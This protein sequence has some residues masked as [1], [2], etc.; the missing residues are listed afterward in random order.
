MRVSSPSQIGLVQIGDRFG[1]QYYLPYAISLLQAYAKTHL[2]DPA[3]VKFGTPLYYRA[4]P[5]EALRILTGSQILFFSAYLWNY[6]LSIKIAK[7]YKVRHPETIIV[8]GGPQVP[9]NPQRL[10][11]FMTEHPYIDI[12]CYGE[13][14]EPFLQILEQ[15]E[16]CAWE[17]VQGIAFCKEG[18]IVINSPAPPLV[19]LDQIPSPYLSG[20]FDPLIAMTGGQQWSAL[21][22]TNRGCPFT[23]AFCY[24][25]AGNR[26]SI[27]SYSLERIM[28]EIDWF[29]KNRIEFLFCCDANFG[30]LERDNEIVEKIISSKAT[31]GFPKAF[32][33]QSTKNSTASIYNLQRRLNQ[34]GLQKGVNLALQSLYP[35]T[36]DA[37]RRSN[38][39]SAVYGELLTLF[40][41]AGIPAFSDIILGLPEETYDSYVNGIEQIIH[42][43]QHT[44][45]QFINLTVLEN[46]AMADPAYIQLYGLELIDSIIVSHHTSLQEA[47]GVT[48][49]QKLVVGSSAMPPDKW[50]KARVF[51]WTMSLFYYDRLL[52]IPF[53][54]LARLGGI[55]IRCVVEHFISKGSTFPVTASLL[56]FI[57]QMAKGVAA[58]KPEYVASADY[59]NIWWQV[60]EYLMIK[61]IREGKLNAFYEEALQILEPLAKDLPRGIVEDALHLNR[62][63]IKEPFATGDLVLTLSY[64]LP[65]IHSALQTGELPKLMKGIFSY[66][67]SRNLESIE[68]WNVW[69]RE[70]IWYGSKKGDYLFSVQPIKECEEDT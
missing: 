67:I 29:A 62:N 3:S 8:F 17:K 1:S 49:T 47:S 27:R 36:L 2:T 33:V 54:L 23:C 58:G 14:E 70:V 10:T 31:T 11:S 25:G 68:D 53:L 32:S 5:D 42:Q 65:E 9:E 69:M 13:G 57:S 40:N 21:L 18:N 12:A 16:I 26:R 51:S 38:I 44:R 46:T 35:P 52:Q 30:I 43:G 34:A 22:E 28:E 61:L 64:Q 6:S 7:L 60:D 59:L 4:E 66:R 56:D 37:I 55:G 20:V 45:I 48:E 15:R 50:V 24:W 63:L 39:S 41:S 19:E